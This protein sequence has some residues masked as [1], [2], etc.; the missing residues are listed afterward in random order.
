MIC[1]Y[2]V[3][4]TTSAGSHKVSDYWRMAHNTMVEAIEWMKMATFIILAY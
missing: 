2:G 3:G 4:V 1:L